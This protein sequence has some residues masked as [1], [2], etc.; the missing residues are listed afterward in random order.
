MDVLCMTTKYDSKLGEIKKLHA[1]G[2]NNSQIALVIG[3][4]HRRINELLKKLDLKTNVQVFNDLP[5]SEEEE[6]LL[7]CIMGDGCLFKSKENINYR[8]NLAHSEKQ[9]EYFIRKYEAVKD[10]VGV[11]YKFVSQFNKKTKKTYY[12][13][14]FQSKVN[15][16]FTRMYDKWYKN[17][18]KIMPSD[19]KEVLTPKLLAYKF[20]DDGYL[21][22]SGYSIS[23]DDYDIGSVSNYRNAMLENFGIE[24]NI[25]MGGKK[26]YIPSS[27]KEKFK[28]LVIPY[29]TKDVLYKLGELTGN[30]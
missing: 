20:F 8:M 11:D 13:Y 15:P 17:G 26:I 7:S 2:L 3:I 6:V 22:V 18:K 16:Y 12:A 28:N 30:S 4:D 29:A 25:H 21:N 24:T 1:E 19:V 27:Q 14:K 9:K 10:F 23:M 5:T